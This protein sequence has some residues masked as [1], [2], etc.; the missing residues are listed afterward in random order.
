MKISEFNTPFN[1]NKEN[2]ESLIQQI[3][4]IDDLSE[5]KEI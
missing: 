5:I 2:G 1:Y 3:L 4:R